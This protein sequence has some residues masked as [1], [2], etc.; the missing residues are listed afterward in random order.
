MEKIRV[1]HLYKDAYPESMGGV[2]KFTNNL[3][4]A[5]NLLG[6]ENTVLA[7]SKNKKSS[8]QIKIDNYYY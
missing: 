4:K 6:I 1:L 2:A 7:F 5:G 8:Y 3:C